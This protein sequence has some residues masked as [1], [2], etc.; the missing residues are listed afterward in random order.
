[1]TKPLIFNARL[2]DKHA[3]PSFEHPFALAWRFSTLD[4]LTNI[5][6]DRIVGDFAV[7]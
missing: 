2:R 5:F 4:H 3:E 1:M 6:K 7:S